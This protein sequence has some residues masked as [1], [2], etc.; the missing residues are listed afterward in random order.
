M[1]TE[2]NTIPVTDQATAACVQSLIEGALKGGELTLKDV[3]DFTTN[4]R[5]PRTVK[6]LQELQTAA[7]VA[8]N[9]SGDRNF[10]AAAQQL[11][12]MEVNRKQ[13]NTDQAAPS[14]PGNPSVDD[15]VEAAKDLAWGAAKAMGASTEDVEHGD[16]EDFK[17]EFPEEWTNSQR[18][19]F[20]ET[21]AIAGQKVFEQTGHLKWA[22]GGEMIRQLV[23]KTALPAAVS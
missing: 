9:V 18:L 20:A 17:I 23:S 10:K 13:K 14:S 16:D 15:V 6:L 19:D 21:V 11:H 1:N 7:R 8:F 4:V 22:A 3:A 5:T 12:F 2:T